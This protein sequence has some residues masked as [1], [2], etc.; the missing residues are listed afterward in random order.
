MKVKARRSIE[1]PDLKW[2]ISE[3][4]TKELPTDKRAAERIL[5]S[6]AIVPI[7]DTAKKVATP[8]GGV[9]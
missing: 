5:Q 6:P 2:A 1:F 7:K 8:K 3:G 9:N 4:Q